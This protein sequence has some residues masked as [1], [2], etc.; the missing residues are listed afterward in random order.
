[1]WYDRKL[2]IPLRISSGTISPK[3]I[4][5]HTCD[6]ADAIGV[7]AS[8]PRCKPAAIRGLRFPGWRIPFRT[9]GAQIVELAVS[10]PLLALLFVGTYDVGQAFNVK[11]KLVATTREAARLAA[12]QSTSD[13]TNPASG[14]CSAPTSICAV[15]DLID[16]YLTAANVNDCGLASTSANGTTTWQWEFDA[17]TGCGGNTFKVIIN[18]GYTYT[19]TSTNAGNTVTVTVEATRVT[20]SYPYQWQ[21]N[22]VIQIVGGN[23]AVSPIPT[24]AVMQNLN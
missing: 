8:M 16:S 22:R 11:Q 2:S 23:I 24:S 6:C 1:M 5:E 14:N 17:S 9:E 15:R 19:T 4:R 3:H 13:L 12:N 18:R 20:M 10:L 7:L 21:F